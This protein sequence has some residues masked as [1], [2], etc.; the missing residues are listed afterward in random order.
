MT[1]RIEPLGPQQ[2]LA[3]TRRQL[4]SLLEPE[5][6]M[7][8]GESRDRGTSASFPRSA[9]MRL[10][11]RGRDKGVYRMLLLGILATRRASLGRWGQ[12]LSAGGEVL[13]AFFPGNHGRSDRL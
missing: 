1:A 6:R 2:R 4:R 11:M 12:Y 10:L 5:A 13:K 7:R 3:A 9:T 8:S